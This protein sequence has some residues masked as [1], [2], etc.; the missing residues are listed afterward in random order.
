MKRLLTCVA[1]AAFLAGSAHA[2]TVLPADL[3]KAVHDYDQAQVDGNEAELN[4]LLADDYILANSSG[5][6]E[7]KQQ[8]IAESIGPR[9]KLDPFTVEQPIEKVWDDGAVMGGVATLT[10][11]SSGAPFK[12][13]LRFSDIWAKRNGTWQ[14]IYTHASR[15]PG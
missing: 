13:T 7:T 15:Q 9:N 4:R 1:A 3:A 6:T 12:V 14:V 11:L 8:F 2:Q 5:A 10:G